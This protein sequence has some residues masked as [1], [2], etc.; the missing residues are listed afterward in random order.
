MGTV[1]P[2]ILQQL[3][4]SHIKVRHSSCTCILCVMYC[5]YLLAVRTVMYL[6]AANVRLDTCLLKLVF[7]Y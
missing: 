7:L 1:L 5:V 4:R 3:A 6:L 2:I